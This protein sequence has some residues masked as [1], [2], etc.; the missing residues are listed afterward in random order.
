MAGREAAIYAGDPPGVPPPW[1]GSGPD[2]GCSGWKSSSSRWVLSRPRS[3]AAN[4]SR[5]R[6]NSAISAW[7]WASFRW[8]CSSSRSA[9]SSASFM[10]RS[11]SREALDLRG[12]VGIFLHELGHLFRDLFQEGLHLLGIQ[13]AELPREL[14]LG[15][16]ER[17]QLHQRILQ[18][19]SPIDRTR[20]CWTKITARIAT[21]GEKSIPHRQVGSQRRMGAR[22]GS[23]ARW[24]NWT[25]GF[26][27]SG[28]TQETR[29]RTMMI[30]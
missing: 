12:P 1:R 23:V 26:L 11:A 24:R 7:T 30:Q 27:G 9:F 18:D 29:A 5:W 13:A 16:L 3:L 25:R 4:R 22:T 20:N 17:G 2:P 8:A 6:M 14:P 10:R 15:D 28:F 19:N 21:R